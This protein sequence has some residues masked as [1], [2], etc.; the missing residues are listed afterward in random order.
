MQSLVRE[1][2]L[3]IAVPGEMLL[4]NSYV[5][6]SD[7]GDIDDV[8]GDIFVVRRGAVYTLDDLNIKHIIAPGAVV[9]PHLSNGATATSSGIN[10]DSNDDSYIITI[11]ASHAS[12]IKDATIDIDSIYLYAICDN[13]SYVIQSDR[14]SK[15]SGG[16]LYH[17]SGE[18]IS[19]TVPTNAQILELKLYGGSSTSCKSESSNKETVLLGSVLINIS[20]DSNSSRYSSEYISDDDTNSMSSVDLHDGKKY[21]SLCMT[22]HYNTAVS[23]ADIYDSVNDVPV[24]EAN[25]LGSSDSNFGDSDIG[26]G[27]ELEHKYHTH[28]CI[29][30]VSSAC[31][32]E[33]EGMIV[34][35]IS[36]CCNSD[37]KIGKLS[38]SITYYHNKAM[39]SSKERMLDRRSA[40]FN[41][42]S[43]TYSHL[44]KL[45]QHKLNEIVK[46]YKE[47]TSDT[48]NCATTCIDE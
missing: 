24:V 36:P 30:T 14:S 41:A 21:E 26:D 27:V 37:A 43:S 38:C 11:I 9:V 33:D 47:F 6:Y 10:S 18:S 35:D 23:A 22:K 2:I 34:Y 19:L 28:D 4:S 3:Y 46:I 16:T 25:L 20:V 7:E 29:A 39:R 12:F 15:M 5:K 13:V 17:W 31:Y 8:T 32:E 45:P 48:K 44:L 1:M 40:T 42:Y